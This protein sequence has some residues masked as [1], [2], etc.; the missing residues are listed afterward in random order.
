MI[1]ERAFMQRCRARIGISGESVAKATRTLNNA[2]TAPTGL[3]PP[4]LAK[5]AESGS[6]QKVVAQKIK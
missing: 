5:I 3:S 4:P 6:I 1:N 2:N